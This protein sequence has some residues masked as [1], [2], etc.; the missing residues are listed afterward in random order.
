M[1]TK[2]V[3]EQY[4]Y[5]KGRIQIGVKIDYTKKTISLVES[6]GNDKQWYFTDRTL[7]YMQGWQRILTVMKEAITHAEERLKAYEDKQTDN[8]AEFIY[9]VQKGAQL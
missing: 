9:D 5:E 2:P 4:I 3:L 8:F 7:E 1:K 6:N